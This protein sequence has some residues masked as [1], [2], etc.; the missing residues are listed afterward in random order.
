MIVLDTH[1]WVNWI[2]LG[3]SALSRPILAAMK[4]QSSMAVSAISCFEVSLLVKQRKLELPLP[5]GEW[6][7]EALSASGVDCLPVT[8][9][10]SRLSVSLQDIHKD[11]ADRIIIATAISHNALLASV[12]CVFPEYSELA[13]RLVAR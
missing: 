10:I 6:L 1:V 4:W 11:P 13:G 5:V 3:E 9:E 12:D 2:L 8:C 7:T